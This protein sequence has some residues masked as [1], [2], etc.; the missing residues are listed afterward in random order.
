QDLI[1]LVDNWKAIQTNLRSAEAPA[2]ILGEQDKATSI[3]RDLLN[4]DFNKVV[5][6]DKNIYNDTKSYI[7]KI[8]PHKAD[9][10]SFYNN[11]SPVFDSYG[12]T[13]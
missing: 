9:I 7:Q 1:A 4:E 8:A 2:K 11:G 3:L 10:V 6:N 13:K 5:V 12:I